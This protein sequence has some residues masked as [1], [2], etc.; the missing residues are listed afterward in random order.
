MFIF[1]IIKTNK[2][3]ENDKRVVKMTCTINDHGRV[4]IMYVC[5]ITERF[6]FRDVIG[7]KLRET[8]ALLD[9]KSHWVLLLQ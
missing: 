7:H 6:D 2:L 8:P 9:T 5:T 3:I 4:R 1:Q